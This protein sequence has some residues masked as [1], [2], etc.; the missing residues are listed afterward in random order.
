MTP[1]AL[2]DR[3]V[4]LFPDFRA[5]WDDS[6][7]CFRD[8]DGSYTLHGVFSEFTGFFR[9]RH[10]A[11]P[12]DR[13]AALGAFVSECMAAA[14][15]G[16]LDNAAATCF[17]E[18]VAGELCDRE[19]SPHLTGGARRYWQAWGGRAQPDAADRGGR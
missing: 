17:V 19:L 4:A 11:L 12:G 8:D 14:D 13:I 15:D 10:A 7:N 6:G 16:Q 3:L 5:Y 2:L 1:Q 9:E 18:N